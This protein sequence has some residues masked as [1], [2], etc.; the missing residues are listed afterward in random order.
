MEMW[1]SR[2]F[3]HEMLVF[4]VGAVAHSELLGDAPMLQKEELHDGRIESAFH[5][6]RM[7]IPP[8]YT[9]DRK[10][11]EDR[12]IGGLTI[13]L[14]SVQDMPKYAYPLFPPF[15]SIAPS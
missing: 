13:E 8:W 2:Q 1:E 12:T 5:S 15:A 3:F 4:D 11:L 9:G 6:H 10:A 14:F 7:C